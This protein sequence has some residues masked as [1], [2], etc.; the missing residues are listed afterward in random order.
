M[1]CRF[2]FKVN[3]LQLNIVLKSILLN[4]P[5]KSWT[6]WCGYYPLVHWIECSEH[7]CSNLIW[8]CTSLQ[9]STTPL[10][11]ASC[12]ITLFCHRRSNNTTKNRTP[13]L[14]DRDDDCWWSRM[15]WLSLSSYEVSRHSQKVKKISPDL[16]S[17]YEVSRHS[18]KVKK[19]HQIT[20]CSTQTQSTVHDSLQLRGMSCSLLFWAE[21]GCFNTMFYHLISS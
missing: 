3:Q 5:S 10:C 11:L 12:I 14:I 18:Q 20:C 7:C 17:S 6:F 9:N 16:V 1:Q 4:N 19:L 8:H 15:L 2:G 13:W 21:I